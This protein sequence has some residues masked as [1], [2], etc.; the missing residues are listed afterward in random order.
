MAQKLADILKQKFLKKGDNGKNPKI[1][2]KNIV[3]N[4]G[5]NKEIITHT[6]SKDGLKIKDKALPSTAAKT[7]KINIKKVCEGIIQKLEARNHLLNLTGSD[8]QRSNA[9]RVLHE[10]HGMMSRFAREY[11]ERRLKFAPPNNVANPE[12]NVNNNDEDQDYQDYFLS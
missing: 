4:S 10:A 5:N 8:E 9:K 1:Q 12:N 7:S 2:N 6:L 11:E 3:N